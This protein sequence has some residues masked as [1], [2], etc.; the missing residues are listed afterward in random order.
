MHCVKSWFFHVLL[1]LVF[2]LV[3]EYKLDGNTILMRRNQVRIR[4]I[5]CSFHSPD[6]TTTATLIIIGRLIIR[7]A[8]VEFDFDHCN[9]QGAMIEQTIDRDDLQSSGRRSMGSIPGRAA[10]TRRNN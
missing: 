5:G 8:I 4:Q 2:S 6:L 9:R 7:N 10:A 3:E 1:V